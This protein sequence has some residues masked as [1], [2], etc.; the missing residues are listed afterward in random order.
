MR[1]GL[2]DWHAMPVP[3][4]LWLNTGVLVLSSAVV[5]IVNFILGHRVRSS[6]S[7]VKLRFHWTA[8]A[9]VPTARWGQAAGLGRLQNPQSFRIRG[10]KNC[11]DWS[12]FLKPPRGVEVRGE[13]RPSGVWFR[14]AAAA[15]A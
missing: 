15:I 7:A 5:M 9:V 10:L 14:G 1:M 2:S 13:N 8:G 12:S 3:R 4:L 6:H 11:L